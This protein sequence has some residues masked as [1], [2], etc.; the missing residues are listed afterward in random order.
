MKVIELG[1]SAKV[2][3]GY[4]FK[5]MAFQ[6]NG[7]PVV[8]IS[9]IGFGDMRFNSTNTQFV[10]KEWQGKLDK[11]YHV[12]NGDILISLTGSHITQPSSVVGRVALYK[13]SFNSL[14]NQRAGKVINIDKE[15][16]HPKYLFY[17][18][19]STSVRTNM[20][21]MASGAASQANI[22]PKDVESLKLLVPSLKNQKKIATILS[23]YDDLI[24]VYKKRIQILENV[25]EELYREWFVRFRFPN[26]ENTEFEKGIPKGWIEKPISECFKVVGG[27]TPS[28]NNPQ[29][30]QDGNVNWFT[31]SDL[32]K[33][34]TMF[35]Q[36]SSLKC[37]SIGL[38]S[39]SAKLFPAYSV[40]MTSRAT[41]GVLSI[42]TTE[43]CTNQ[44]F[45]TCLPNE[46]M[47]LSYLYYQL[48]FSKVYFEA[49]ATG[50]TFP[51]LSR[52]VFKKIELRL[53][54][55]K[56][57]SSFD[58]VVQPMFEQILTFQK[59]IE[60]LEDQKSSLFPRLMSGKLSVEDLDIE[61]PPSI[62]SKDNNLQ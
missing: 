46:D 40:M 56:T 59:T 8:K 6:D 34:S 33:A 57:I 25:A 29:F 51:E 21:L 13:E 49:L 60:Q 31:P 15:T 48:K 39:S 11:K 44:G 4:A 58:R 9:N 45:I 5:S 61:F 53:A 47:P 17:L 36:E 41:I 12:T 19:N 2:I 23:A 30:W 42:N 14:L 32:T 3:S 62:Q 28:K 54:D 55:Q 37:N 10:D 1:K 18:L 50:A 26:W 22:S 43:A 7:I 27:G 16:L 38:M 20:A 24:D 52:G 35:I